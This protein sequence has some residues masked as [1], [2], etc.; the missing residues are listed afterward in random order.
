MFDSGIALLDW[1]GIVAFTITGALAA[2]RNQM[3]AV[4]FVLLG[5]V[6]GIGGGTLRDLLLAIHPILWIGRPLYLGVCGGVSLEVFFPSHLGPH[7]YRM[8]RWLVGTSGG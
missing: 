2:S 8:T 3:D 6:T 5:T 1:I 7:G 4:G